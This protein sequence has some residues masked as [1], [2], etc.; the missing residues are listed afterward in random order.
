MDQEERV[1]ANREMIVDAQER[2]LGATLAA[3]TRLSG[4]GWL[5]SAITLGGGS[6]ACLLYTS[7]AA[8]E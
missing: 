7:D 6:L 4:P 1:E 8:D 3:Y 5:A 2:G